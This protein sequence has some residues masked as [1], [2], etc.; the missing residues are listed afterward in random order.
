M[1]SESPSGSSSGTPSGNYV[2]LDYRGLVLGR[3]VK[4]TQVRPS[5]G[6]VELAAPMPVGS[7]VRVT[8]ENGTVI[9]AM[10]TEVCEQVASSEVVAGMT[11]RPRLEGEVAAWW[12]AKVELPDVV[13]VDAPPQIGIVR[14]KRSSIP[15][16]VPE[17]VDDARQPSA[18]MEASLRDTS[19]SLAAIVDDG[20]RTIA[21]EAV[22]LAA[23]G[24]E[25]MSASGPIPVVTESAVEDDEGAG[26][27]E[28][29][30]TG[31]TK[32]KRKRR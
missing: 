15:S 29:G 30:P 19:P 27:P 32:K 12:K 3:H 9:E 20:K 28:S 2:D 11:I 1:A 24:L 22:D 18:D 17:L 10:V 31:A 16:A 21:M 4:L 5:T 26:V 8:T 23:L 14:P 7:A 25:P 13:K 6:Y